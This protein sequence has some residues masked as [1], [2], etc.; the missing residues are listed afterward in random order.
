MTA[1]ASEGRIRDHYVG[2]ARRWGKSKQMAMRDINVK[3]MEVEKIVDCIG[4]LKT[5]FEDPKILEIGCGNGYTAGQIVKALDVKITCID[6]CEDLIEIAKRRRLGSVI[7]KVGD[8]LDLGFN[9]ASFDIVLSERCLINLTS[10]K[11]QR[12]ALDEVWRVLKPSGAFLMMEAFTDGL[13]NLNKARKAV[14]L[15]AIPQPPHDLF[16]DKKKFL[17]FTRNKFEDFSVAHPNFV[18]EDSK[19]FLSSYYFGSRVLY[20]ALI[21]NKEIEYNNKFLEFFKYLPGYGNFSPIQA[22]VF[23]REDDT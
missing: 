10:W 13:S 7:F 16:L 15:E 4:T 19:N 8:V 11:R 18:L 23:Q 17:R 22:L 2:Q 5:Y 3:D 20:P 14:G 6:F 9:D 12:K 21:G 1:A